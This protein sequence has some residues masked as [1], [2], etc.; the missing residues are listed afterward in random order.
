MTDFQNT[1]TL[2]IR[3]YEFVVTQSQHV[4]LELIIIKFRS[5]LSLPMAEHLRYIGASY[6]PA[7]HSLLPLIRPLQLPPLN[8]PIANGVSIFFNEGHLL[9]V[10][11]G[12]SND[13]SRDILFSSLLAPRRPCN[14]D[15]THFPAI[16]RLASQNATPED[17]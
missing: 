17:R 4:D 13:T 16:V 10:P 7:I 1:D 11:T 2:A 14:Q 8:S 12:K 6:S 9:D 3:K 15:L 5:V